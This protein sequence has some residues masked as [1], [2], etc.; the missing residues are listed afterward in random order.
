[1]PF[2]LHII[3][4][5]NQENIPSI[6]P[7]HLGIMILFDLGNGAVLCFIPTDCPNT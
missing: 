1:M 6:F 7:E 5:T 3:V 2:I 4:D